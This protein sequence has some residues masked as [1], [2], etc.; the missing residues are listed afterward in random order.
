MSSREIFGPAKPVG[1]LTS[2]TAVVAHVF[3]AAVAVPPDLLLFDLLLSFSPLP[4]ITNSVFFKSL[5]CLLRMKNQ[6]AAKDAIRTTA[7][8][9]TIAGISVLK[10]ESD[11]DAFV[12]AVEDELAFVVEEA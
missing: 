9:T 5:R 4:A 6:N 8:G 1:G 2:E 12:D 11:F 3:S 7:I 10:F